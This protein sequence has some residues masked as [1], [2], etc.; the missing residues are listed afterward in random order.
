MTHAK[1]DGVAI[2]L[3]HDMWIPGSPLSLIIEFALTPAGGPPAPHWHDARR[4]AARRRSKWPMGRRAA[5]A[6]RGGA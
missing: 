2:T 4:A 6:C 1:V 3:D 5:A